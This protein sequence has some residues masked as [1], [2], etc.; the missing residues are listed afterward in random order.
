MSY[1]RLQYND[2][3][4]YHCLKNLF[5]IYKKQNDNILI[6][7]ELEK[8]AK[9]EDWNH[10]WYRNDSKFTVNMFANLRILVW[11]VHLCLYVYLRTITFFTLPVDALTSIKTGSIYLQTIRE[12]SVAMFTSDITFESIKSAVAL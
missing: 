11:I 2:S 4:S 9:L 3:S 8:N 1:A 10:F 12:G 7:K 6:A 5:F